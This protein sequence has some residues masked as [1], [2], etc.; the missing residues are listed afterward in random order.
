M[1]KNIVVFL[2]ISGLVILLIVLYINS[3]FRTKTRVF[4]DYILLDSIWEKY[5]LGYINQDGRVID[6]TDNDVT[7]S[8]GQSYA[9][10]RSVWSDDKATFDHVWKWTKE[11]LGRSQDALFGWRW[12]KR[13]DQTYGFME[14]GGESSAADA[15]SDIALALVFASRRWHENTY[16]DEAKKIIEDIWKHETETVKGKRYL[17]PGRWAKSN[18]EIIL[19]P[20]YFSPYSWKIFADIDKDNNWLSLIEPAYEVL[21]ESGTTTLDNKVGVGLPPDWVS[22]RRDTNQLTA[23]VQTELTSNYSYDAMRIPWRIALDYL[24]FDDKKAYEYLMSLSK[25]TELYESQK[26]L[27]AVYDHEGNPITDYESP[28]MYASSLAYFFIMEPAIAQEMYENKILTLYNTDTNELNQALTYYDQNW[29]WFS[30][31]LYNKELPNLY[32][33]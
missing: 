23:P 19:N 7:T 32:E 17:I 25:L 26:Q 12:G 1:N 24:W 31:A 4:S 16:M 10:L 29:L 8:E 6:R 20:S 22:L 27:T 28:S 30:I 11:N 5:K 14:N 15:D 33:T 2:T 18:T 21:L 9:M 3:T 13:T